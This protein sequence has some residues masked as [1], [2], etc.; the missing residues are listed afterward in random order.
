MVTTDIAPPRVLP[1]L[2]E[3]RRPLDW[4]VGALLIVLAIGVIWSLATNPK[5]SWA[6]V[7]EYLFYP[8]VLAGLGLT[9][10]LTAL[11][12]TIG[13]IMAMVL[14]TMRL[15]NIPVARAFAFIFVWLFRAIPLLVLLIL[16]YNVGLIFPSF[17][18]GLPGQSPIVRGE[19]QD[20][21]TPF[22]AGVIAFALH[23]S[24]YGSE[25]VRASVMSVP[26]GQLEAADAL[27]MS[28]WTRARLVIFPQ[29]MR[30]AIPPLAN[31]VVTMVKGTALVAFIA[32]PDLLYSVQQI[33]NANYQVIPLLLVAT[34]WYLVV[35]TILT[36]CQVLLERHF[37]QSMRSHASRTKG[38]K[39]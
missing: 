11:A 31:N 38:K 21:I 36:V 26:K 18:L 22:A 5:L 8:R 13:L 15:S 24:S 9:L 27:G 30:I 33:Y 25:I 39:K 7:G 17:E 32:V 28:P 10:G 4:V 19:L 37:G 16:I 20:Y 23:E 12:M 2:R 35:V 1:P 6:V 14:A 29:A 34:I 3:R